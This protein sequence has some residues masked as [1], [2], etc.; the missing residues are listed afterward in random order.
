MSNEIEDYIKTLNF[1]LLKM[2]DVYL[3]KNSHVVLGKKIK[4]GGLGEGLFIGIG[5]KV[6]EGESF[7]D[8]ARREVLEEIC[9]KA[10]KLID[11]GVVYF[12]FPAKENREKWNMEVRIYLCKHWDGEP[13]QSEEMV[14]ELF[15]IDQLPFENMWP[16]NKIWLP[17]VLSGKKIEAH[18]MY[19]YDNLTIKT[20]T[21]K[22][23]DTPAASNKSF[24]PR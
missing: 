3:V 8:G 22:I 5:G 6:E 7:E 17:I 16:D 14:P 15:K 12:Y 20:Y 23:Y 9:I 18:F 13:S 21:L 11:L 24:I 10:Q 4:K 1:P 2:T 19:N